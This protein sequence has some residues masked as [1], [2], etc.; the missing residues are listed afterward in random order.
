MPNRKNIGKEVTRSTICVSRWRA[1]VTLTC[2]DRIPVKTP[3]PLLL[4]ITWR[5]QRD[6]KEEPGQ[7]DDAKPIVL[8]LRK[9]AASAGGEIRFD[10]KDGPQ[11][12]G[13][14]KDT[15]E[16]LTLVGRSAST[17]GADVELVVSIEDE[18]QKPPILLSV[19]PLETEVEI[20]AEN[21]TDTAPSFLLPEQ[22]VR[23]KAVL[24][25]KGADGT[26]TWL[27]G[28]EAVLTLKSGA[29]KEAVEIVGHSAA[30]AKTTLAVL[31]TPKEGPAVLAIHEVSFADLERLFKEH[32][33]DA[34]HLASADYRRRLEEM[35]PAEVRQFQ[36]KATEEKIKKYLEK[37]LVFCR[38]QDALRTAPA[39]ARES[40]VF[41]GGADPAG[42]RN[43]FYRGA[44]A[45]FTLHPE[46]GLQTS[47]HSLS[48]IRD[49]LANNKP[50][51]GRPWGT[52]SIVTHAFAGGTME[53]PVVPGGDLTDLETLNKAVDEGKLEPLPDG[54]FDVLTTL[55]IRGCEIGH[56]PEILTALSKAFGGDE[57]QR[58][59]VHG[60][61]FAQSYDFN[62]DTW[63][64]GDPPPTLTDE[65]LSEEIGIEF[66]GSVIPSNAQLLAQFTRDRP[67]KS[68]TAAE[69]AAALPF[70]DSFTWEQELDFFILPEKAQ[71]AADRQ[72]HETMLKASVAGEAPF[73]TWK[74]WE[75]T[76]RTPKAD[77]S[78]EWSYSF[79]LEDGRSGT[80]VTSFNTGP[81]K[82]DTAR[83]GVL[84]QS[85]GA[86][87]ARQFQ[88][89]F[90][91]QDTV[92]AD[93]SHFRTLQ[94][95]GT[96]T[97]VIVFRPLT[98][99]DP[100]SPGNRR[101]VRPA[102][103]DSNYYTE[104]I[105]VRPPEKPLGENVAPE[106]P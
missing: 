60:P 33:L 52:V 74:A 12:K 50:S 76:K 3:A 98:E 2:A 99:P 6:G 72:A 40:I 77:G 92:R 101:R 90:Q 57:P 103:T 89:T 7:P 105:P 48:E 19:G 20:K 49:F 26:F 65:F 29:D 1:G 17:K 9:A 54:V 41:I 4:S 8:T 80:F 87:T 100:A 91:D 34:R 96:K 27:S 24:K 42:T 73:S 81:A 93:G 67:D 13:F 94:A 14:S 53:I 102:L 47:F 88:W 10:G 44:E 21:G 84:R 46:G 31:F 63:Q 68:V 28:S 95:S 16:V 5:R 25:G 106:Q 75:L 78:V 79:T 62:P 85:V 69:V 36:A 39:G 59:R 43:H 66:P 97:V 61:K 30:E 32:V 82:N 37:L 22:P 11:Q 51:N 86:D 45:H 15:Q 18:E 56:K 23:L 55:R 35:P 83:L 38:E 64:T 71:S 58:P 104:E 70:P